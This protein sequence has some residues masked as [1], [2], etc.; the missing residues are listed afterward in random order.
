[1]LLRVINTAVSR[2]VSEDARFRENEKQAE[3]EGERPREP[4]LWLS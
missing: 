2:A 3:M 4:F 1:M